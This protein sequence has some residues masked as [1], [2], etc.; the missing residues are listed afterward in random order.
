MTDE[1]CAPVFPPHHLVTQIVEETD[2]RPSEARK[3]LHALNDLRGLRDGT[4][5]LTAVDGKSNTLMQEGTTYQNRVTGKVVMVA[6][7][8]TFVPDMPE[9]W[10]MI[11]QTPPARKIAVPA[12]QTPLEDLPGKPLSHPLVDVFSE[13]Q[14]AFRNGGSSPYHGHSLEHIVHAWGWVSADLRAALDE[15]KARIAKL[16]GGSVAARDVLAE[17]HRQMD[18]E[19]WT[20]EHD[21]HH[22]K[23]ELAAAAACYAHDLR[24]HR[25]ASP[26]YW[27]W[28]E[29]WWK[30]TDRRRDLVKAGALIIAEI[31][32]LDRLA[33]EDE[34]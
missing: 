34:L 6:P 5:T 23:G 19:G 11:A 9:D 32:R 24:K 33:A 15:A 29:E 4:A 26:P 16:E 22:R 10:V 18:V 1:K 20:P 2:C 17:R 7:G 28:A 8:S 30:P 12:G 3:A 13:G 21:D 14:A 27:P 31:E 25:V